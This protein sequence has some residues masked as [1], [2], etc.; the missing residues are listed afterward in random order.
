MKP[1]VW[2]YSNQ[3]KRQNKSLEEKGGGDVCPIRQEKTNT[4]T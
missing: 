4:F 1:Y 2:N 3:K